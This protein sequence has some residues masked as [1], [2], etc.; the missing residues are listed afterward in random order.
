LSAID[1]NHCP[2][3]IGTGVRNRWNPHADV[4]A[5]LIEAHG[6]YKP[7]IVHGALGALKVATF[8]GADSHGAGKTMALP[9]ASSRLAC[10]Q[11]AATPPAPYGFRVIARKDG[12]RMRLYSRPGNDLTYRFPLE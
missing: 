1:R 5:S 8:A 2:L 3:S 6:D 11:G 12:N 4:A 7:I 10:L 9:P